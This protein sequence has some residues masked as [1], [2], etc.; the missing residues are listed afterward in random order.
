MISHANLNSV[1]VPTVSVSE[2]V[3]AT[4]L[5]LKNALLVILI[6]NFTLRPMAGMINAT[7]SA[8]AITAQPSFLKLVN[9]P[10]SMTNNVKTI[11]MTAIVSSNLTVALVPAVTMFAYPTS[12][13]V[14][15]V[16]V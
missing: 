2:T 14:P 15:T 16:S 7:L 11:V 3:L 8:S 10:V 4:M 1:L 12:V 13:L 6:M 5:P 9:V